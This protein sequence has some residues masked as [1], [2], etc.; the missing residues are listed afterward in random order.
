LGLDGEVLRACVAEGRHAAHVQRDFEEA[1][2]LRIFG[3]PAFFINGKLESTKKS[4]GLPTTFALMSAPVHIRP[5]D[6][7]V[8]SARGVCTEKQAP[9]GA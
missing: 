5:P 2:R 8:L 3:T 6:F 1:Q 7:L 9:D 4:G